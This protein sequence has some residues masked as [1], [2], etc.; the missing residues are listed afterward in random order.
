MIVLKAKVFPGLVH[1]MPTEDM[2]FPGSVGHLAFFLPG[3]VLSHGAFCRC[4]FSGL[5][6]RCF[7]TQTASVCVFVC[8][9]PGMSWPVR[10]YSITKPFKLHHFESILL[11]THN[12][13]ET[14]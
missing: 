10:S 4:E 9:S 8:E 3:L 1:D 12:P 14:S 13:A 11:S 6:F 2:V 5:T 7:V